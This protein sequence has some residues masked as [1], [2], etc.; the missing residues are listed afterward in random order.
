M[1][2]ISGAH[3]A[4]HQPLGEGRKATRRIPMQPLSRRRPENSTAGSTP[5]IRRS[6]ALP[7]DPPSATTDLRNIRGGGTATRPPRR[8]WSDGLPAIDTTLMNVVPYV[9]AQTEPANDGQTTR[10][11]GDQQAVPLPELLSPI[12]AEMKLGQLE[13]GGT[14]RGDGIMVAVI[15]ERNPLSLQPLSSDDEEE[16]LVDPFGPEPESILFSPLRPHN[17]VSVALDKVPEPAVIYSSTYADNRRPLTSMTSDASP[18]WPSRSSA[19]VLSS[20][21]NWRDD[22]THRHQASQTATKT[23]HQDQKAATAFSRFGPMKEA[24][25]RCTSR[26]PAAA[27][28]GHTRSMGHMQVTPRPMRKGDCHPLK[29]PSGSPLRLSSRARL[30]DDSV[31]DNQRYL[32]KNVRHES[33]ATDSISISGTAAERK[34]RVADRLRTTRAFDDFFEAAARKILGEGDEA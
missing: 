12:L 28:S 1:A 19:T 17:V 22:G 15:E 4:Y 9:N 27:H 32:P 26:T 23:I 11:Q 21:L 18:H 29:L 14:V 7:L 33:T 2:H 20:H 34:K 3:V 31:S 13:G 30:Q 25:A 10:E 5:Y 16:E 24:I 8:V 6:G